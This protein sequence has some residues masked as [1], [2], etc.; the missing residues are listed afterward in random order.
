VPIP[1]ALSSRLLNDTSIFPKEVNA[2]SKTLYL[3]RFLFTKSL[4]K[5]I[6]GYEVN[7]L[8]NTILGFIG[9]LNTSGE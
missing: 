7:S 4:V 8:I 2:S 3:S 6:S 9:K 5:Y 1:Q